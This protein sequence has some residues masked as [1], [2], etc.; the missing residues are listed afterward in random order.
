LDDIEIDAFK[1]AYVSILQMPAAFDQQE[2]KNCLQ[3]GNQM[4]SLL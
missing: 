2:A 3:C 4:S 1:V